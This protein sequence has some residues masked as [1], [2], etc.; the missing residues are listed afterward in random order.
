[1][2]ILMT[3]VLMAPMMAFAGPNSKKVVRSELVKHINEVRACYEQALRKTPNLSGQIVV[4][5]HVDDRGQVI[6][7]KINQPQTTLVSPAVHK[8]MTDKFMRWSFPAA[9]SGQTASMSFP[10]IFTAS[11]SPASF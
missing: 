5:W 4:D 10:F 9:P 11:R 1:M 7:A 2:R 8:C 6:A 3:L